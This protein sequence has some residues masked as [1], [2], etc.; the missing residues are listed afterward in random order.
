MSKLPLA[1]KYKSKFQTYQDDFCKLLENRDETGLHD[2]QIEA[3]LTAEEFL[4]DGSKKTALIVLPTGCGKSGIAVLA[5]YVLGARRVLV[6]TPSITITKQL[7]EDIAD[8]DKCFIGKTLLPNKDVARS[9]L[10]S[11]SVVEKT[12]QIKPGLSNDIMIANAH[13]FGGRSRVRIEEIP[14]D[15]FDLV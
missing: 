3:L 4:R 14:K 2:H 6:V 10:P 13:K 11:N 15:N 7:G 12:K 8:P 9:V 5:P 1:D